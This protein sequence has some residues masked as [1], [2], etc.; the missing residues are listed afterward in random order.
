MSK[1][2]KDK[3]EEQTIRIA[4]SERH[5][6]ALLAMVEGYIRQTA[7]PEIEKLKK[8]GIRL[9]DIDDTQ[10]TALAG[11]LII[12][13]IIVKELAASGVMKPEADERMGIDTI[14][15]GTEEFK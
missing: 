8:K 11:P 13:G 1:E 4:L 9:E 12:R 5:W 15:E 6:V 10:A 14:L 7:I 3:H 2:S